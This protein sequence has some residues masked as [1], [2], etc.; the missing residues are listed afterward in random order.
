MHSPN[1]ENVYF[2]ESFLTEGERQEAGVIYL[3]CKAFKKA[4]RQKSCLAFISLHKFALAGTWE[5]SS[6][7]VF[8][9][10][11]LLP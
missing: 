9:Q 8:V 6:G 3:S 11:G 5:S 1:L 10:G 2:D 4:R 7:N